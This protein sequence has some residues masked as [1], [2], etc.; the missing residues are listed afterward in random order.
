MP[1]Q[2][3]LTAR[4][5]LADRLRQR[6][7]SEDDGDG[8]GGDRL[9]GFPE[10]QRRAREQGRFLG[11]GMAMGLKGTGRGPFKSATVRIDRS[12]KVTVFTGAVA[13]GQGIKTALA[14][15]CAEATRRT[16]GDITVVAGDT[17][18][19]S[20][21]LGAFASRQTD[22]GWLGRSRGSGGCA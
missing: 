12:G 11:I 18:A 15:I 19:I 14:Q 5:G 6:R 22:H 1:Y 10:R 9:R 16:A 4:S 3:G 7:L 2:T 21:G 20:L 13:I 8:A 17:G